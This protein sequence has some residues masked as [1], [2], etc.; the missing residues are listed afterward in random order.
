MAN[1]TKWLALGMAAACFAAGAQ[2]F[3]E[4]L[5]TDAD[6]FGVE[7]QFRVAFNGG[8][9]SSGQTAPHWSQKFKRGKVEWEASPLGE[10]GAMKLQ[11]GC[12]PGFD[13][14]KFNGGWTIAAMI[15]GVDDNGAVLLAAGDAGGKFLALV[16]N[17]RGGVKL[18]ASDGKSGELKLLAIQE[19]I[20]YY[21]RQF[22]LYALVHPAGSTTVDLYVDGEAAAGYGKFGPSGCS[23]DLLLG[24][25]HG[26]A[27][28][29]LK[30]AS[31]A[32]IAELRVY[33]AAYG[34]DTMAQLASYNNP[35]PSELPEPKAVQGI[36]DTNAVL[37]LGFDL[38]ET[39]TVGGDGEKRLAAKGVLVASGN[40]SLRLEKGGS[41]A[42]GPEGVVVERA[43]GEEP[44]VCLAGGTVLTYAKAPS[45]IKSA[46]P[47]RLE[48]RVK[49]GNNS[50]LA[51]RAALEGDGEIVKEGSGT[52]GLQFPCD[53]ATG[54]LTVKKGMLVLGPDA[55]WGGT[56]TLMPGATLKCANPGVIKNLQNK[57]GKIVAK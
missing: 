30:G 50:T 39:M 5:E 53:N 22:H 33:D 11:D 8:L 37:R 40:A 31:G 6:E 55:T 23:S 34:E 51:I 49:F 17:G 56:V 3:G 36:A 2:D 38:P 14:C 35:W 44:P 16:G 46:S 25:C 12:Y 28:E 29:P 27:K 43:E 7:P 18:V 13:N 19:N 4:V 24:T 41:L 52:L 20:P 47:V 9:K 48:G 1:I 54:K 45:Q 32:A 10:K 21:D 15:K 57:G 26:G 42:L